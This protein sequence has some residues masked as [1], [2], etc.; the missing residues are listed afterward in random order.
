MHMIATITSASSKPW[1]RTLQVG[2]ALTLADLLVAFHFLPLYCTVHRHTVFTQCISSMKWLYVG[3]PVDDLSFTCTHSA[4]T[5]HCS[6]APSNSGG[7]CSL[8][9]RYQV[10]SQ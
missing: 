3:E 10:V 1:M 2:H 9:R 6:T 4:S 8:C 5:Q 7:T